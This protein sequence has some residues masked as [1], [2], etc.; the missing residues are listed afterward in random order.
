MGRHGRRAAGL[1]LFLSISLATTGHADEPAA[2]EAATMEDGELCAAD[3][4]LVLP[5]DRPPLEALCPPEPTCEIAEEVLPDEPPLIPIAD[6]ELPAEPVARVERIDVLRNPP[7]VR[8]RLSA[9]PDPVV[10]V[11]PPDARQPHRI[12][13]DLRGAAFTPAARVA[14]GKAAPIARIR[15]GQFEHATARVVVELREPS[16]HTVRIVGQSLLVSVPE[17]PTR[18]HPAVAVRHERRP[19]TVAALPPSDPTPA[20]TPPP[21]VTAS[22]PADVEPAASEPATPTSEP[23]VAHA[24]IPELM[25]ADDRLAAADKLAKAGRHAEAAQLLAAAANGARPDV[26]AALAEEALAA[27]DL[28]TARAAYE[29]LLRAAV[30]P[31]VRERA[32]RTALRAALAAHEPHAE[33]P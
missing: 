19:V 29:P 25:T 15:T 10:K 5:P 21:P 18:P 23:A 3:S 4:W 7:T 27:G 24:P 26:T 2:L 9:T 28:A 30:A 31:D 11:L 16:P 12:Y 32:R 33:A 20:E 6:A 14:S 17:P 1:F 13:I 8:I 22:T